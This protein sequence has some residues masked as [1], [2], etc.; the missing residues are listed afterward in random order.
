MAYLINEGVLQLNPAEDR[1]INVV[2][3][4]SP[5]G[6]QPLQVI[7][8]RDKG[9]PGESLAD[10][11]TR[12]VKVLSRQVKDFK[13]LAREELQITEAKWPAILQEH[14]FKQGGQA[15][16]QI[17]IIAQI[18]AGSFLIFSLSS[19]APITDAHRQAWIDSVVGFQAS[20]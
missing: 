2:T 8:T 13:N 6:A 20:I 18:P 11:V 15:A 3:L 1:S 7:I 5:G 17:Q 14:R 16:H 10:S 12:Q 4:Q 19:S 9:E